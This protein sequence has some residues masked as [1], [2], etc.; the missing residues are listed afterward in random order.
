MDRAVAIANEF[1]RKQGGAS[2]TQMQIQKLVYIA[3]GWT[4]ALTGNPLT[5][6]EPQ[7]WDYGPVYADLYDHTKLFG[8]S[9]IGREITP[10]DDEPARF[11]GREKGKRPPYRASLNAVER[12]IIDQVW[13]RY[14][15]L[16]GAR[17]SAV[18]HQTGTPWS[19]SY[20]GRKNS[21][22][23]NAMIKEHYCELAERA[24]LAA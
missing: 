6:E 20:A 18:T 9:P 24:R 2:L 23:T 7:A 3:H 8:R 17:L 4:L 10:D 15:S 5:I 12:S 13:S 14:G 19:Q 22:I 16:S 21:A 11:F 1:L